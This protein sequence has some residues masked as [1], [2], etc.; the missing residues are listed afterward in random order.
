MGLL[1]KF[2]GIILKDRLETFFQQFIYLSDYKINEECS[3][4]GVCLVLKPSIPA[5]S[6]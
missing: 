3:N 1:N 2:V 5:K 6:F 4:Q